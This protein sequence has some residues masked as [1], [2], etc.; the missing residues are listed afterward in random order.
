M[1]PHLYFVRKIGQNLNNSHRFSLLSYWMTLLPS[2]PSKDYQLGLIR[3]NLKYFRGS[4][5]QNFPV[6]AENRL[7]YQ[8]KA[9]FLHIVTKFVEPIFQ[10][11]E[12]FVRHRALK[13]TLLL[14]FLE[15]NLSRKTPSF[16]LLSKHPCLFHS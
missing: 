16:E 5:S 11:L 9:S 6:F 7:I 13:G 3:Q 14:P 4:L 12:P 10:G 15:K 2:V 1:C 8:E